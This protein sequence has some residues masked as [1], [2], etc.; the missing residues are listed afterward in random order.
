MHFGPI[1]RLLNQLDFSR[2]L[3]LIEERLQRALE[4]QNREPPLAWDGLDPVAL[5]ASRRFLSKVYIY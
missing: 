5:F 3:A 2:P 4:P 1:I